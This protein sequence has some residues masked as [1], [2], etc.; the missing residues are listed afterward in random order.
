M[1]NM[2]TFNYRLQQKLEEVFI[3]KPNDLGFPAL[4]KIYHKVT[5]FFKTTPFILIIPSSFIV[6]LVLYLL[7]GALIIKLVSLL[8]YGF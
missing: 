1:N 5:K 2:K 8:Q 3:L 6:A 4:T 7:L